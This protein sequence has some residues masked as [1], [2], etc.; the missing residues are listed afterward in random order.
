MSSWESAKAAF[1]IANYMDILD[2]A[3]RGMDGGKWFEG[4]DEIEKACLI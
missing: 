2:T 1:E 4:L 3:L